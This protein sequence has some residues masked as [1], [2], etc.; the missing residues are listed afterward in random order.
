MK[1]DLCVAPRVFVPEDVS[2]RA[3]E[4]ERVFKEAGVTVAIL[5]GSLA[6]PVCEGG[7]L[8]LAVDGLGDGAEGQQAL[9]ESLC[10][11][12]R[13]DNIDLVPLSRAPFVL[14]KR[15]LLG[16]RVLYEATPGRVRR[17][18]E[19]VL[20]AQEDFGYSAGM[21]EQQLRARLRG[22]LSGAERRLDA[23]RVTAYLSQLDV[24][25]RKLAQLRQGVESFENFAANEDRRDLVVHHLRIALE[26]VLD[27]CRHFLAV[28]GVSLQELDTTNLIELAGTRGL[29]P[30]AFAS[31]IRGMAGMR[32]AIVRAYVRLAYEAIHEMLT[33]RLGDFD[34]F[35]RHV[36]TYLEREEGTAP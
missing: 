11:L 31:R 12:F 19:E 18:I 20:F 15:A 21:A 13:A 26:C 34:E 35:G 28:K 10:R 24:S 5:F 25:V 22:G 7:D 6:A 23:D 17:M 30:V 32:N 14:R 29:F 16:G 4:L 1:R 27:I 3:A 33:R 9:Y 2:T 8:D 36:L